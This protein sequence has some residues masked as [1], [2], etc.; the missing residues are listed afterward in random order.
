M[1]D[2]FILTIFTSSILD[3]NFLNFLKSQLK[4]VRWCLPKSHFKYEN[5]QFFMFQ[6]ERANIS[7]LSNAK[8]KLCSDKSPLLN[9]KSGAFISSLLIFALLFS[10]PW[11]RCIS[12]SLSMLIF[13][14]TIALIDFLARW[15]LIRI[16]IILYADSIFNFDKLHFFCWKFTIIQLFLYFRI[17]ILDSGKN[18]K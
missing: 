11:Y 12:F 4:S 2:W 5:L 13:C 15:K 16:T 1:I 9:Q 18:L 10:W 14:H 17:Y 7:E 6:S 8:M 3:K